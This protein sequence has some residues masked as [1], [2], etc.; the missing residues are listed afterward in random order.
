MNSQTRAR[1]QIVAAAALFSTGGVAIK[2]TSAAGWT[3]SGLRAGIACLALFLFLPAARRYLLVSRVWVVAVPYAATVTLFVLASKFTTAANAI[4]LQSTAPFYVLLLGPL[5][6]KEAVNR[7]DVI[8]MGALVIGL[9]IIVVGQVPQQETVIDSRLGN[10]LAICAGLSWAFALMGMR[11]LSRD[12]SG[13][14]VG[15]AAVIAG[16][17]LAVIVALPNMG[18]L[19]PLG[20]VD[21]FILSYLGIVQ[22]GCAYMF[23]AHGMRLVSAFSAALLLLIEPVLTPLWVWLLLNEAPGMVPLL[24]GVVII[25]ATAIHVFSWSASRAV[26]TND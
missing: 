25:G 11:W 3:V 18:P 12:D 19:S 20:I 14:S 22:I 9:L 1:L 13:P 6:L 24:G 7:R 2:A 10:L 8:Y 23:L 5:L 17:L 4:F 21:W 16:N 26:V 15:L